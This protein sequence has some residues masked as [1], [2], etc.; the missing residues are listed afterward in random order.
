MF[1]DRIILSQ[2]EIFGNKSSFK[3]FYSSVI[4]IYV[5]YDH[6]FLP[7]EK[8][9]SRRALRNSFY[10]SAI[11][12]RFSESSF[13]SWQH[14]P[15]DHFLVKR[16]VCDTHTHQCFPIA[17]WPEVARRRVLPGTTPSDLTCDAIQQFRRIRIHSPTQ[18]L[19]N[20]RVESRRTQKV[21]QC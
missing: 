6:R 10:C 20:L 9:G 21:V 16:Q 2:E 12:P 14:S 11:P 13:H 19:E 18:T 4:M 7:P 5:M 17:S 15:L 1:T 8:Y 3:S